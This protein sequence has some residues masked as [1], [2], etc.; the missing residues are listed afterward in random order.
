ML[1]PTVK[2]RMR[3]VKEGVQLNVFHTKGKPRC[4]LQGALSEAEVSSP[5]WPL[6][7]PSA[8]S[9]KKDELDMDHTK[10]PDGPHQAPTW[11]T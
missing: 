7:Q 1:H 8:S 10:H 3:V 5:R 4:P 9:T 11:S 6:L 2:K